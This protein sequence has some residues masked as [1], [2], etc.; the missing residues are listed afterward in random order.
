MRAGQSVAKVFALALAALTVG[1]VSCS[2]TPAPFAENT[3]DSEERPTTYLASINVP[4]QS[5]ERVESFSIDTWGVDVLAV[6]H[7]PSGWRITAGRSATPD[8]VIAG[9][10]SHGTTWLGD[11]RSLESLVLVGLYGPVQKTEIDSVP[12]TFKG[13]A[14]VQKPIV[15]REVALTYENVRLVRADRCP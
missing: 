10:G 6:C 11:T 13:N 3:A 15:E 12:A 4:L 2:R 9:E 8:G 5:G 7:I 1:L 14:L